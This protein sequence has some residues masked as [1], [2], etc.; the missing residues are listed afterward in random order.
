MWWSRPSRSS[1]SPPEGPLVA[2]LGSEDL[3]A[4]WER[5][6]P[7]HSI[8]RALVVIA[9]ALPEH[10]HE[11][12]ARLPLG[13]RDSLLLDVRKETF[14]DRVEACDTC[15]NCGMAVEVG[16]RCSALLTGASA[17]PSEWPVEYGDYRVRVRPL[18]SLDA[19]A[20]LGCANLEEARAELLARSVIAAEHLG[21]AVGPADL[22]ADVADA[23]AASIGTHDPGAELQLALTCPSCGHT[24][25]NVLDVATF[26]WAEL[27]ALAHGLL[28]EVHALARRYAWSE[29]E[30]LAMSGSRRAAYLAM[31]DG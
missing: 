27:A 28:A 29:A 18:D 4:L 11:E 14:G 1:L 9:Q 15:S 3:L 5:G 30:I 8:D 23:V 6:L 17:P 7:L 13:V 2:R 26:V 10:G 25:V 24:W 22:P 21:R 20:A 31:A 16:L 19:V 12:L